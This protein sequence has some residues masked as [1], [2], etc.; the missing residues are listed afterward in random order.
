MR[1]SPGDRVLG[2]MVL[3]EADGSP[4]TM[5][6]AAIRWLVLAGPS[7]LYSVVVYAGGFGPLLGLVVFAWYLYLAYSTATDPKRQG[8]HDKYVHSVVV[9]ATLA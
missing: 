7:A 1:A 3:K 5:N 9:K 2:L 4:L 6:Q 8:F